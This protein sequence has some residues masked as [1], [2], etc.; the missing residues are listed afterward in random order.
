MKLRQRKRM[1]IL[2]ACLIV[3]Q[4]AGSAQGTAPSI[5][6]LGHEAPGARPKPFARGVMSSAALWPHSAPM[7]SPDGQEMYFAAFYPEDMPKPKDIM[8]VTRGDNGTWSSPRRASFSTDFREDCPMFSPDGARL[9]FASTRPKPGSDSE[10]PFSLWYVER[11]ADGGWSPP[12]H[13]GGEI[14][15]NARDLYAPVEV[16]SGSIYF[17][18]RPTPLSQNHDIYV[19]RRSDTGG[20]ERAVKLGPMINT[21]LHETWFY[22]DPDEK[23]L[24]FF[25]GAQGRGSELCICFRGEDGTWKQRKSMGDMINN[26]GVRMP[27]VSPDGLYL[28]F[29]G[30]EGC[31]W[32]AAGIIEYLRTNDLDFTGRLVKVVMDKSELKGSGGVDEAVRLFHELKAAHPLYFDLDERSLNA[33]GY[34]LL[35]YRK[36][37]EAV[38]LFSVNAAL[39]PDSH[40]V[41]DSLGEAYMNLGDTARAIRNYEK[42]L[43]L[44]PENANA[45]KMLEKLRKKSP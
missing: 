13:L 15:T 43:A 38:A 18:G 3:S 23:Y 27:V 40:N 26:R 32:C 31:W 9:L 39:H 45:E 22:V 2:C 28:F 25:S 33:K 1:D 14:E 29:Q 6:Y 21:I 37:E 24:M 12:V 4:A 7:F 35:R 19:A 44:N 34:Q 16:R 41:Y 10:G 30:G 8:V 5:D 36:K 20:F 17:S 42:S 11:R